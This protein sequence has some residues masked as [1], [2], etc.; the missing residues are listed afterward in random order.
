MI[1]VAIALNAAA[2]AAMVWRL[3]ETSGSAHLGFVGLVLF[4]SGCCTGGLLAFHVMVS[5]ADRGP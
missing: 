1:R 3:I 4:L 2:S 5:R